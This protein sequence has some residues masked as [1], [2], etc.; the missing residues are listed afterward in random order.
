MWEVLP[1]SIKPIY[2]EKINDI[3]EYKKYDKYSTIGFRACVHFL[4]I[5]LKS[6]NFLHETSLYTFPRIASENY[7]DIPTYQELIQDLKQKKDDIF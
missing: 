7:D 1:T 2:I 6:G 3:S 4:E 5:K